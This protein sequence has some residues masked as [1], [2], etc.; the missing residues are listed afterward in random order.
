MDKIYNTITVLLF[1][2]SFFSYFYISEYSM[3]ICESRII[4]DDEEAEHSLLIAS[5]KSNY[6]DEVTNGLID[7]LQGEDIYI[8]VTDVNLLTQVD[9]DDF[10]AI[11][12]LHTWEILK[13]PHAVHDFIQRAPGKKIFALGTSG[14]GDM[15]I[16]DV[17]GMSGASL[18]ENVSSDLD[19]IE[20]WWWHIAN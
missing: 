19:I 2:L 18:I 11:V 4:N 12:I 13:P 8:E 15:R 14:S 6:K 10:D 20:D 3:G 16:E 5:Q 7:R 9:P 17:D 1:A